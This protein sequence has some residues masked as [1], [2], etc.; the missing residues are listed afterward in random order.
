MIRT[1]LVELETIPAIAYRE[2]L[3]TGDEVIAI[4]REDN[5]KIA[6]RT[7]D[8]LTRK[9]IF[10]VS[11]EN[12]SNYPANS[13]QEAYQITQGFPYEIRPAI[14]LFQEEDLNESEGMIELL[15]STIYQLLLQKYKMAGLWNMEP[16][17]D[18]LILFMK[19]GTWLKD[20]LQNGYEESEVFIYVVK[21]TANLLGE[22]KDEITRNQAALLINLVESCFV[23]NPFKK[24]KEYLSK[25][26]KKYH[27]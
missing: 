20:F 9:L 21:E 26:S 2:K 7:I 15:K 12:N 22:E 14:S 11:E 8:R 4:I 25:K 19:T 24:A 10:E 23:E 16:W 5:P 17:N 1:K 3:I 6:L 13:F 18:E 27:H